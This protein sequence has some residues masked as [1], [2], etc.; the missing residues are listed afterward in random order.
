MNG[1]D[2]SV[3][4]HPGS[5]L[6]GQTPPSGAR[7]V[8]LFVWVLVGVAAFFFLCIILLLALLAIPTLGHMKN[9]ANETAAIRTMRTIEQAEL[10]YTETYPSRGYACSLRAMGGEP[11]AGPPSA[12]AAQ[13]LPSDLASGIKSG[14]IFTI[15]N[16]TRVSLSGTERVT[17]Y[18]IIAI[19]KVPG[20]T[21]NRGFCGDESG[22]IKYDP[23]G[24]TQCVQ[25]LELR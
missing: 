24:G 1:T 15:G 6:P 2:S 8:P 17:G 11:N 4:G 3:A 20:K 23:M 12:D 18:T 16:C 7:K 21:G 19:P 22:V 25:P 14:Y 9:Q 5:G 10:L 13:V